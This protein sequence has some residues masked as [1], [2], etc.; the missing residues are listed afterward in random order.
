MRRAAEPGIR[1]LLHASSIVFPER[2]NRDARSVRA[3]CQASP[4]QDWLIAGVLY[5][6]A[7]TFMKIVGVL[8][9]AVGADRTAV[10]RIE[11]ELF[12]RRDTNA[13]DRASLR[14][15]PVGAHRKE[16]CPTSD[17]IEPKLPD[18]SQLPA[19]KGKRC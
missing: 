18:T 13:K 17:G 2:F 14:R 12:R 10:L 16:P 5:L 15:Q 4:S 7:A 6:A 19:Q 3:D 8:P 1:P 9:S 11:A